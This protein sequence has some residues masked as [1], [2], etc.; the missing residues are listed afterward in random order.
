MSQSAL[1]V[2]IQDPQQFYRQYVAR[3][4]PPREPTPSQEFGTAVE[5]LAFRDTLNA[6]VIPASALNA[7]GHRKGAAWAAYVNQMV[8]EHGPNVKLCKADEFSK[9]L[10]PA[11]VMQAVDNLRGHEQARNLIW[12]ESLKNVRIRWTD[13]LTGMQCRCEIDLLH[14]NSIIG[15]LKTAADVSVQGFHRAVVN[16]GYH[17]QAFFYREALRH[18]AKYLDEQPDSEVLRFARPML[19]RIREGEN[20]L[21]CWVAVKNKPSHY[22]ETHPV[23]EAW[24]TIAE[25][26]VRQKMLEL[27]RAHE[28]NYWQTP[29]HGR[30][31][32]LKPEK[33]AYNALEQLSLEQE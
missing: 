24:Y 3:T 15:D 9:P 20:I 5:D 22:A 26:I 14:A 28:T 6:F 10:G 27:K 11:A 21:C 32:S 25:P 19:E 4:A 13:E 33:W 31:T 1:K 29:T 18:V 12:G 23:D 7:D 30:F 2:F 16:F 8:N 17:I